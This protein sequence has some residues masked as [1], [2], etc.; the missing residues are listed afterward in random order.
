MRKLL[1]LLSVCYATLSGPVIAASQEEEMQRMQQQLNAETMSQPFLAEEPEKV[2]AY[3]KEATKKKL[4]P[5]EYTGRH[6]REGY[7]CHDLLRYSWTEYRDCSY[8]YRYHGYY[9]PYR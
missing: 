7:T 9:Y 2:D 6:W 4:K 3:I 1:V 5:E 8:Y